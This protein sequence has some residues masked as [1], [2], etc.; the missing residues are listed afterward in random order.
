MT[1][2]QPRTPS[3]PAS[4]AHHVEQDVQ[5]TTVERQWYRQ[6][7]DGPKHLPRGAQRG[8]SVIQESKLMAKLRSPNIQKYTLVRQDRCQGP[9][10]GLLFFYS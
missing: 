10:G 6:Q 2:P 4:T 3:P 7:T 1:P 9:G 8:S 5:H